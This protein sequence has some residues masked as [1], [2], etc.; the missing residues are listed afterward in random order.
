[1]ATG[2]DY[3]S[4]INLAAEDTHLVL[5][6]YFLGGPISGIVSIGS[7]P[8]PFSFAADP[9][10]RRQDNYVVSGSIFIPS[11]AGDERLRALSVLFT[12]A[13]NSACTHR[14]ELSSPRQLNFV[15]APTGADSPARLFVKSGNIPARESVQYVLVVEHP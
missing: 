5:T 3:L 12:N 10:Y 9:F 7:E 11:I 2:S 14:I 4:H 13:S 6:V 1:M 8:R 15:E